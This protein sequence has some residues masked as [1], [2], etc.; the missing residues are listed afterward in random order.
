VKKRP[1]TNRK[2]TFAVL[3]PSVSYG[4]PGLSAMSNAVLEDLLNVQESPPPQNS[5]P[6]DGKELQFA[7]ALNL[8]LPANTRQALQILENLVCGLMEVERCH[9]QIHRS[10]INDLFPQQHGLPVETKDSET[11]GLTRGLVYEGRMLGQIRLYQPQNGAAFTLQDQFLLDLLLPY[12]SVHVQRLARQQE[13]GIHSPQSA[14][15]IEPLLVL[16]TQLLSSTHLEDIF[17]PLVMSVFR[18][19][20][21]LACYYVAPQESYPHN[22]ETLYEIHRNGSC[23]RQLQDFFHPAFEGQRRTISAYEAWLPQVPP[24]SQPVFQALDQFQEAELGVTGARGV[25]LC[26]VQDVNHQKTLGVLCLFTEFPDATLEP[27]AFN[28][29]LAMLQLASQACTRALQVEASLAMATQDELTGLM[30][31]RAYY[32]RFEVEIERACRHQAPLSVA[33]LDVDHFKRLNDTYGHLTGD[34]ALKHLAE[35]LTDNLRK[36]DLICRFGG[37]EFAILLPDTSLKS[38]VEL[39]ERVRQNVSQQV[40]TDCLAQNLRLTFSAGVVAVN[41]LPH[42][43]GGAHTHKILHALTLADE[44]LYRA[45]AQGRNQVC[46]ATS[47]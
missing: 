39:L 20:H 32:Q 27:A 31:R 41:T 1:K 17:S 29:L 5:N 35:L 23:A 8:E 18:H 34:L 15:H 6:W 37:E 36:S 28:G 7:R 45:K 47:F 10:F 40:I 26:P 21:P 38:A 11:I 33:L 43:G 2:A 14:R 46:F 13:E 16:S 42:A 4:L 24:H 25:Y 12:V 44:Q 19:F 9:I 22:G 30:T 3:P